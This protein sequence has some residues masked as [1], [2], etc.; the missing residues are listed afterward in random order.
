MMKSPIKFEIGY[1]AWYASLYGGIQNVEVVSRTENTITVKTSWI[2][3]DTWDACYCNRT[4]DVEI[5]MVGDT[6]IERVVVW[7]YGADKGYL[8]A[9]T[10]NELY[11]IYNGTE[12]GDIQ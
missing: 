2:A 8:Y 10:D 11:S 1:R 4:F 5:D 6:P 9:A 7:T 12:G 3:E